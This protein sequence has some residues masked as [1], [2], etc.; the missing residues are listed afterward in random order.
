MLLFISLK[1]W[2]FVALGG[3]NNPIFI[4]FV[5]TEL[6]VDTLAH[7]TSILLCGN[8]VPGQFLLMK[9]FVASTFSSYPIVAW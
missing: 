1:T 4:S 7:L 8:S 5:A 3:S 9:L 2:T 6:I